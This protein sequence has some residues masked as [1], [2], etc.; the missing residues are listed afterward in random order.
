MNVDI[1]DFG[2]NAT[3]KNVLLENFNVVTDPQGFAFHV[4]KRIL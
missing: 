4:G 3:I 2:A 1:L